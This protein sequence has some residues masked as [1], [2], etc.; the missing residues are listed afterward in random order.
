MKTYRVAIL[1]CRARGTAQARAYHAHPRTEVVGLCD[2]VR[3]RMDTLGDELGVQARFMDLDEMIRE[4][5]PD[6]VAIPTGTEFHHPL[7]M[8]V[9]EHGVNIEVEKPFCPELW[10]AD[11]VLAKARE[12]GARVAVHHQNR[13]GAGIQAIARAF[14]EGRIGALRHI[15]GTGKGYYGGYDLMNIGTHAINNMLRFAGHVRSVTADATTGER[16][17]TPEDVLPSPGGMGIIAGER[18]TALFRFDGAVSGTLLM[19]RLPRVDSS[20]YFL[21][22]TGTAGRLLWS[23]TTG[24]WISASPSLAPG[25]ERER[26]ERLEP[27]PPEAWRSGMHAPIDDFCFVDETV[28]ALDEGRDHACSGAEGL[29]TLEVMMGMFESAAYGRRVDLPQRE[30][31]HP[32]LRWRAEHG[33]PPPEPRPRDYAEWLAAED[34]RTGS[35]ISG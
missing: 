27:L 16:P 28:K 7:A 1:G 8:R 3:E 17:I 19:H 18:I 11:A 24:A 15:H 12:K 34:S 35:R 10:Q 22:L 21:E 13:V 25:S 9:L 20:A 32:L 29:H 14:A 2:L 6:I 4:M 30:R 31:D 23:R 5:R 26:W 33:L